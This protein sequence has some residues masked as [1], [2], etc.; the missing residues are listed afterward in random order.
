VAGFR[1]SVSGPQ[2]AKANRAPVT[3]HMYVK[4]HPWDKQ[5]RWGAFL[6]GQSLFLLLCPQRTSLPWLAAAVLYYVLYS[7]NSCCQR[8]CYCR[9]HYQVAVP[10]LCEGLPETCSK[11][12]YDAAHSCM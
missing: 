1:L 8:L 11:T 3:L 7:A 10:I 4:L 12:A 2:K 9:K 6:G 5:L